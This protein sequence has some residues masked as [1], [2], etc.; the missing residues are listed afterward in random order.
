M[1][2]AIP[3]IALVIVIL[4]TMSAG[5]TRETATQDRETMYQVS[6]FNALSQGVYDGSETF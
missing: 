4:F 5:C 6:A 2:R 1:K 3:L